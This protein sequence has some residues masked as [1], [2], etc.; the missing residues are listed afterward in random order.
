MIFAR[1]ATALARGLVA[2]LIGTAAMTLSST[3]EMR[4]RKRPP[5]DA[6]AKAVE[7]VLEIE[8]KDEAAEERLSNIVHWGYG[9]AWGVARGMLDLVGLK[10]LAATLAHFAAVWGAAMVMLPTVR[11]APPPTEWGTTELAIDGFHH[12]VYATATGAAYE[13]LARAT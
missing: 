9:T 1:V 8:P 5:S 7:T 12:A 3:I 6:P 13:A 2:G 11:A 4:A 10:G